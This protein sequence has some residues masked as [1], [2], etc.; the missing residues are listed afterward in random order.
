MQ[1]LP[2]CGNSRTGA[3]C[4]FC[5]RA[6]ATRDHVPSRVLLDEPFPSDLPVIGACQPCNN[7]FSIDEEYLA[8]LVECAL[9]G[10]TDPERVGRPKVARI[11]EGTPALRPR[12]EAACTVG[13]NGCEFAVEYDRVERVLVKLAIGHALHELNEVAPVAPSKVWFLPLVLLDDETRKAFES[14]DAPIVWPEVG[15]R[16][17]QRMAAGE[18]GWLE[19]QPGR[20]RFLA[21]VCGSA[22]I[23]MVL[24]EYLACEVLWD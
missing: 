21:T 10:S 12:L 2:T 3:S 5:G 17:M 22:R 24:S 16:A 19:V 9:A 20:Y 15:S 6:N 4:A 23:R 14:V 18:Y 13:A 8:C 7:G 1:P 11:L